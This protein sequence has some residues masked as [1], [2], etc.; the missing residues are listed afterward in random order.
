MKYEKWRSR[1]VVDAKELTTDS[2]LFNP[3][4]GKREEGRAG[5]YLVLD[6]KEQHI[7]EREHFHKH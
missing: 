7:V 4:T 6:G 1:Q 3:R 5:D 2:G